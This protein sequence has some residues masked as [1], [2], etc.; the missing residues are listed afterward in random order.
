M[1]PDPADLEAHL[2]PDATD[3]E[4]FVV[5]TDEK[6]TWAARKADRARREVER[7]EAQARAEVERIEEWARD[8]SA[9]HR[10][11]FEFFE[12]LLLGYLHRLTEEKGD[13]MPDTYKVIGADLKRRK[14]PDTIVF[15]DKDDE[16]AFTLWAL[17]NNAGALLRM[18]PIKQEIKDEIDGAFALGEL[19]LDDKGKPKPGQAAR[20]IYKATGEPI[21]GVVYRV[22]EKKPSV[23]VTR[24]DQT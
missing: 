23:Q 12:G 16:S 8:A 7:I 18:S 1:I 4:Q 2:A 3:P 9:P 13:D 20:L 22:G 21:P 17:M 5:D 6:A 15:E 11:D 14:Q 10:S 24:S 19:E